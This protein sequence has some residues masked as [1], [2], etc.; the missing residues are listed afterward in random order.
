MSV[1]GT[2]PHLEISEQHHGVDAT[3]QVSYLLRRHMW[4]GGSYRLKQLITRPTRRHV[5]E[6]IWSLAEPERGA[7]EWQSLV[8][9][10]CRVAELTL[11]GAKT[12]SA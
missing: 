9:A 12:S 6:N 7:W 5:S 1:I 10:G 4:V 2:S 8:A 3:D 11:V